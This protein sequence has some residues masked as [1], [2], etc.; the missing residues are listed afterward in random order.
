MAT[1]ALALPC[2]AERNIASIRALCFGL[3]ECCSAI[4]SFVAVRE[5]IPAIGNDRIHQN[6]CDATAT[7]ELMNSNEIKTLYTSATQRN[8]CTVHLLKPELD[9]FACL[10]SARRNQQG[11]KTR[12]YHSYQPRVRAQQALN[13]NVSHCFTSG[14]K[15]S[16]I[17]TQLSFHF[18]A[19]F[20]F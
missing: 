11:I 13:A 4:D 12:S 8:H 10:G 3:A 16:L 17:T 14:N 20:L 19:I 2:S 7:F 18:F 1:I 6:D 15:A 9:D 5:L